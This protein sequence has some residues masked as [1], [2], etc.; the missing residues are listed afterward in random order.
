MGPDTESSVT[1][2]ALLPA[3]MSSSS[4]AHVAIVACLKRGTNCLHPQSTSQPATSH[5]GSECLA[6]ASA[7]MK[8]M[9]RRIEVDAVHLKAQQAN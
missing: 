1:K 5:K 9:T 6:I 8:Q 4:L 3:A 7:T 2:D